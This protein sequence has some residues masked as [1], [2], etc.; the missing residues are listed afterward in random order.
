MKSNW[1]PCPQ[2]TVTTTRFTDA[3][4]RILEKSQRS[5]RKTLSKSRRAADDARGLSHLYNVRVGAANRS[6]RHKAQT[7]VGDQGDVA[8]DLNV[9]I[10]LFR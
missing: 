5:W 8:V 9:L 2:R 10:L 7:V 6:P 4:L 3:C 1:H